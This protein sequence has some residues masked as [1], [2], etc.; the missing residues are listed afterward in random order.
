MG[1]ASLALAPRACAERSRLDRRHDAA[2]KSFEAARAAVRERVGKSSKEEFIELDRAADQAWNRLQ[3]ARRALDKHIR[4]HGCAP[5][6]R[7][8]YDQRMYTW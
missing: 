1:G 7:A 4:E 2:G 8:E 3:R 6:E 5:L